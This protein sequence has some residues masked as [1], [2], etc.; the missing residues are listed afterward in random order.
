MLYRELSMSMIEV[1]EVLRR[2][3][4]GDGLRAI[5]RGTGL[6]RKTLA[7]FQ[8]PMPGRPGTTQDVL[9]P[10]SAQIQAWLTGGPATHEDLPPSPGPGCGGL[11]QHALPLRPSG[12]PDRDGGVESPGREGPE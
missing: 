5:A 1:R 9:R 7:Q 3:T 6:D 2:Y 12:P 8:G 4:G 11:L 10:P